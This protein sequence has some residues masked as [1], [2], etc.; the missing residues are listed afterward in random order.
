VRVWRRP[1][2]PATAVDDRPVR[3]CHDPAV[4]LVIAFTNDGAVV[5]PHPTGA[6]LDLWENVYEASV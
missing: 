2:N 4:D 5:G 6:R 3:P 1:G